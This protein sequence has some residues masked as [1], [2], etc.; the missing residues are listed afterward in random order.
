MGF[1]RATQSKSDP[2]TFIASTETVDRYGDVILASGWDL[3][4]F[5]KNPIALWAHNHSQPIGT[6][7]D[8]R[9]EEGSLVARLEMVKAGVSSIADMVRAFVEQRVLRAVSV[10]FIPKAAE[11]R[12]DAKGNPTGG[13]T[14]TK[15]E[16]LE[17]SVVSVPANQ[18]A[19]AV[20]KSAG[21]AENEIHHLLS[22]VDEPWRNSNT[23]IIRP[24][25]F[26]PTI[27]G[28]P[29]MPTLAER[30]AQR[31]A[32]VV[33]L[34][35]QV[36]ELSAAD[37]DES[38]ETSA[39]A[40]TEATR[41]LDE[42]TASLE[43][44]K[45]AQATLARS[46]A[47]AQPV[48][49]V[50]AS[51][52]ATVPAQPKAKGKPGEALFKAGFATF[53]AIVERRSV[54][55][56][57]KGMYGDAPDVAIMANAKAATAAARTDAPGW[58]QELVQ[59]QVVGF[60]TL[61]VPMSIWAAFPGL[62]LTF[63]GEGKIILPGRDYTKNVSG[64][65]VGEG[66][67]IP[68]KAGATRSVTL[69]PDK[70]AVII[71]LTRELARRSSPA[72][73]PLFQQMVLEDTSMMLDTLFLDNSAA[74]PNVRPA[75]LQTLATGINT[76]ASS[77]ATL[78]NIIAD[79]KAMVAQM[80]TNRMGRTPVWVMSE[81]NRLALA[82]LTNDLGQFMFKDE[83]GQGRMFGYPILSSLNVPAGVVFLIDANEIAKAAE[84][85]PA[86][87]VSEQ[88]TIHMD[89]APNAELGGVTTGLVSLWQT[90]QMGLRMIWD[91]TWGARQTGAV[92][93]LTG[94]AW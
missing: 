9:V 40:L 47:P 70:V 1:V 60:A 91:L 82:M 19:L 59:D 80:G 79:M 2:W 52:A 68:V 58:A 13:Y 51:G 27:K 20:G 76:R 83:I 23:S 94:V 75:G 64:G 78:Q 29:K 31:E 33:T 53:R 39:A 73:L 72:A 74:V 87:D 3:R 14:F 7:E 93:T 90:D 61:L 43:R 48:A 10:G 24:K 88:A 44:L 77:G 62:S 22:K 21:I 37:A 12:L 86:F 4:W 41:K 84:G 38:N 56:V 69:T 89:S 26:N 8:V 67:A 6:W 57:I 25:N 63:G 32:E 49:G 28:T 42:A 36:T 18:E 46:A 15:S 81:A 55:D 65:F 16:L 11:P 66:G 34:R 17:I 45:S 30:I 54:D 92:Q 35:D 71:A 85:A 50:T 5:K